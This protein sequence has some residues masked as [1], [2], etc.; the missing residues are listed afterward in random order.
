MIIF[1]DVGESGG[2]DTWL[3]LKWFSCVSC[4]WAEY[5]DNFE[6]VVMRWQEVEACSIGPLAWVEEWRLAK[7]RPPGFRMVAGWWRHY[8]I[9]V[10]T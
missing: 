1:G 10:H 2:G 5:D 6:D 4:G 7:A 3:C 8:T 9:I